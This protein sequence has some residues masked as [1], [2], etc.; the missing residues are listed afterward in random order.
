MK[1]NVLDKIIKQIFWM[2]FFFIIKS[3]ILY[4]LQLIKT[5]LNKLKSYKTLYGLETF[6]VVL[7]QF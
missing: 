7:A 6:N 2:I 4:D 1:I 3:T 5:V